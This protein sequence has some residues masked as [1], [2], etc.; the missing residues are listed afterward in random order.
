LLSLC[1]DGISPLPTIYNFRSAIL[2]GVTT[3]HWSANQSELD[4]CVFGVWYS[5]DSPV[6]T[7]RPPDTTVWYFSSQIEYA[8]TFY[9]NAPAYAAVA[10]MRT[11]NEPE[12][13]NVHELSL[14]WSDV[15]PYR[16]DDVVLLD[17]PLSAIDGTIE[18][19]REDDQMWTMWCG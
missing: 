11:G 15:P 1:L 5:S 4:D 14:E 13:G 8:T 3:I 9:Q 17:K 19:R 10:A 7:N 2:N 16:P 18:K 12:T 6:D